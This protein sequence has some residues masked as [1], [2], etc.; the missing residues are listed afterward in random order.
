MRIE[1]HSSN[2]TALLTKIVKD[3][4]EGNNKTWSIVSDAN[5]V[6]YF[7]HTPDQWLGKALL[8]PTT[9]STPDRLILSVTWYAN[10][11]PNQYT[12]G[13]YI[14]RFTEQ[15]LEHYSKDFTKVETFP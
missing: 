9:A 4:K 12:K 3:I 5:K 1:I 6:E 7:T 10:S 13:L 14:G 8:K 11:I 2:P 15:L